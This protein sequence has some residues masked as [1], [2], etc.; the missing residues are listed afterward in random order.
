M[1]EDWLYIMGSAIEEAPAE[2]RELGQPGP[3][4]MLRHITLLSAG[5]S[6]RRKSWRPDGGLDLQGHE[7]DVMVSA[8]CVEN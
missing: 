5:F 7:E 6:R 2:E 8:E 1:H 4:A 3:A